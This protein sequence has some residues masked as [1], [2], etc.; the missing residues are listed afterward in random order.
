MSEKANK[1]AAKNVKVCP[2]CHEQSKVRKVE[3]FRVFFTDEPICN[4][5]TSRGREE[6]IKRVPQHECAERFESVA[7]DSHDY[8][9]ECEVNYC[10]IDKNLI[11][12][13]SQYQ[14]FKNTGSL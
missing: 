12:N 1:T 6:V 4:F 14:L 5:W 7:K 9:Y 10:Y 3:A 8:H 11:E 2:N 13:P